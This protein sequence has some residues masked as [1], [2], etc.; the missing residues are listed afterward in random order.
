MLI[1]VSVLIGLGCLSFV[2][3]LTII[4]S[5]YWPTATGK[6][7]NAATR[8]VS[9]NGR[10]H[11]QLIVSYSFE[12][13]GERYESRSIQFLGGG[14]QKNEAAALKLLAGINKSPLLV[15]YCPRHP[16]WSY[17]LQNKILMVTMLLCSAIALSSALLLYLL[18]V[19]V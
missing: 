15:R 14:L 13:E 8:L 9:I 2:L 16:K 11:Y 6:L 5:K 12:V 17:L 19:G 4:W 1:A 10:D 18:F 3:F 7:L